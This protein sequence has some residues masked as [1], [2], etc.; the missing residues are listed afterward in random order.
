[1]IDKD[2]VVFGINDSLVGIT[3]G[4]SLA[5]AGRGCARRRHG[6]KRRIGDLAIA[7][8]IDD[9]VIHFRK[10]SK[11]RR[12]L[13]D[14]VRIRAIIGDGVDAGGKPKRRSRHEIRDSSDLPLSDNLLQPMWSVAQQK[15]SAFK[16]EFV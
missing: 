4:Q 12:E 8:E 6:C 9:S 1:R 11:A 3:G 10:L 5:R 2:D 7:G 14:Y 16:W 15:V 13:A